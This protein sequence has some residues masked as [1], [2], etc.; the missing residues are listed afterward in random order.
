MVT[1]CSQRPS[2]KYYH[3][4]NQGFNICILR[5]PPHPPRARGG[6][7]DVAADWLTGAQ[8]D[9]VGLESRSPGC[10]T[11]EKA[12]SV[13]GPVAPACCGLREWEVEAGAFLTLRH[14]FPDRLQHHDYLPDNLASYLLNKSEAKRYYFLDLG[15]F[16]SCANC[17]KTMRT[18]GQGAGMAGAVNSERPELAK[19]TAEVQIQPR[20]RKNCGR[21]TWNRLEPPEG[22]NPAVQ[23]TSSLGLLTS[24]TNICCSKPPG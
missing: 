11:W 3:I 24:R 5:R 17:L 8:L 4:G 21:R 7:V 12:D 9:G 6:A 14:E 13:R 2:S 15:G 1:S 18:G 22:T 20:N 10:S 23:G 16:S 19:S